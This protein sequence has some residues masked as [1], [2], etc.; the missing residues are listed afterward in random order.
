MVNALECF[1]V[2]LTIAETGSALRGTDKIVLPGVG[3]FDAGMRG[4]KDRGH[5][6]MLNELVKV[7]GVPFLGICLGLQFLFEGSE[8]GYESGL[9]WLPGTCKGFPS[10]PDRPK[11]PHMGWSDIE[12]VMQDSRLF[13]ELRPPMTFYFIHSYY[14]PCDDDLEFFAAAT[15][16]HGLLFNAA[17]EKDNVFATQF[18]PEKSQLGGM[19][20]IETFLKKI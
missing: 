6:D 16:H 5:V 15:C 8:E 2:T 1:E 7:K 18:H 13:S 3:S 10:G 9:A 12:V 14:A 4:L 20:L 19:K 11:V 17:I